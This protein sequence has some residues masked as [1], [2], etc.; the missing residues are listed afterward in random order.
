MGD[1]I[2]KFY[3]EKDW[4]KLLGDIGY[5]CIYCSFRIKGNNYGD[6]IMFLCVCV[7]NL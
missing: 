3:F 1:L 7:K 4:Y 6:F 2:I 5:V